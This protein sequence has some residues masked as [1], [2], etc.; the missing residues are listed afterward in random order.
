VSVHVLAKLSPEEKRALLKQLLAERAA[1]GQG[2]YQ[3]SQ[4]QQALWFLQKLVPN[5]C[6]YN[7]S[8][9]ARLAPR[10][11]L[12][13]FQRAL[14]KVVARHSSLRTVF[15]ERDGQPI[16]R[17]LA[18]GQAPIRIVE[19][20]QGISDTELEAMVSA[21]YQRPFCLETSLFAV[22]LYR[23][24]AED[25]LLIN[26]HHL[27]FDAWS[28][29]VLFQD[30]RTLYEAE[31]GGT[32]PQLPPLTATYNNFTEW[33]HRLIESPQGD[34]LWQHWSAIL[35]P[36]PTP[37]ELVVTKPR[38]PLLGLHGASVPFSIEP[39]L[40]AGL[41]ALA[42][43]HHT[44][45]YTVMLA[46]MQVLLHQFS[47]QKDLTIGTPVS[48]RARQ[49]WSNVVGYFINM[50][51]MRGMIDRDASFSEHLSRARECALNAL[52]HQDFPFPLMVDRLKTLREPNRS[53]IFQAMLNVNVTPKASELSR[54]FSPVRNATVPFGD[55]ELAPYPISQQ[56][57]QFEIVIEI[58]EIDGTLYGTLKYHTE[59]LSADTA[60][61]MVS[62][63]RALLE[64]VVANPKIRIEELEGATRDLIVL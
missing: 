64:T 11:N 58:A 27:V 63:Y 1:N 56:E 33:Q 14:D 31:L 16:Q 23:L 44:T 2:D 12:D 49:E 51:P 59:L 9:T 19:L 13:A 60:D 45:L 61:Q 62:T 24:P 42:K 46:T 37:L 55:S 4:G 38:P 57:G 30:L 34:A 35:T 22:T 53:P 36:E 8:F 52:A 7:V 26:V 41:N 25:I 28:L 43:S 20:A 50:L 32:V 10:L 17:V 18:P 3:L 39:S 40:S 5:S 47:G 48:L 6:A 29:Q 54:L 21:D 15:P